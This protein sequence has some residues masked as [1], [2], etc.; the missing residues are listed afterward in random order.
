MYLTHIWTGSKGWLL[1][2]RHSSAS[3]YKNNRTPRLAQACACCWA[4]CASWPPSAG[5]L[6]STRTGTVATTTT[7][8]PIR[9]KRSLVPTKMRLLMCHISYDCGLCA[10]WYFAHWSSFTGSWASSSSAPRMLNMRKLR[11]ASWSSGTFRPWFGKST[12]HFSGTSLKGR[13]AVE[14]RWQMTTGTIQMITYGTRIPLI[15]RT[16]SKLALTWL[17]SS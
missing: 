13:S 15:N 14:T 3:A 4:R 6:S 11:I 5:T 9:T 8:L 1:R 16:S 7:V 2:R 17:A 10:G 12:V